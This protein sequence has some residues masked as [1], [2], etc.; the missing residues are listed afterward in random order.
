M[1]REMTLKN[2]AEAEDHAVL[3]ERHL[4]QQRALVERLT[5]NGNE[6]G[7][8]GALLATLQDTQLLHIQHRD[9]LI[10]ELSDSS[11]T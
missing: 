5:R 9:R 1:D 10:K 6:A 2:L 7:E 8:A 3:G 11:Q 4:S